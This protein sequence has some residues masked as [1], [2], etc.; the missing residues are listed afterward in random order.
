VDALRLVL[1]TNRQHSGNRLRERKVVVGGLGH[2]AVQI[3]KAL[4]PARILA[5]DE[6]YAPSRGIAQ[7][8]RRSLS[9]RLIADDGNERR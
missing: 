6:A 1:A 9:A 5:V 7:W 4:T 3:L 8:A 2:I